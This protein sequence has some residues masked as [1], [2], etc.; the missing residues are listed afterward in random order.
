MRKILVIMMALSFLCA[1]YDLIYAIRWAPSEKVRLAREIRSKTARKL[2]QKFSLIPFGVG[3]QMMHEI[4]KL[5]LDFQYKHGISVEEG[6][7]LVVYAVREFLEEINSD[8]KIRKYLQRHPFRP[9][10]VEVCIFLVKADGAGFEHDDLEVISAEENKVT[11]KFN[12][13]TISRYRKQEETFE[14]ACR[15]VDEED[16]RLLQAKESERVP[17][18]AE[19]GEAPLSSNHIFLQPTI[20]LL[21]QHIRNE[22]PS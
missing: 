13:S 19:N 14:E 18:L 11:F 20:G 15:I 12:N 2:K 17:T 7:R 10:N 1:T 3:G 21:R 6:R 22:S 5:M 9:W 4:Q 8:E 16:Q